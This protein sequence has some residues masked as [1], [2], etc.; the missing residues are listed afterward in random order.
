MTTTK[1]TDVMVDL[2]T[3]STRPNA[4]LLSAGFIAF[5]KNTGECQSVSEGFYCNF[6]DDPQEGRHI[7]I[8]TVTWWMNQNEDARNEVFGKNKGGIAL[9]SSEMFFKYMSTYFAHFAGFNVRVWAKSP[10]FDLIKIQD[11]IG[12]D[13]HCPWKYNDE[14]CVRTELENKD[15]PII[16]GVT[17]HNAI[18][19]AWKQAQE[20]IAVNR[21]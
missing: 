15:V 4:V 10:Q 19:D 3:L 13:K 1:F 18:S 2:E 6:T 9:V 21:R 16:T 17:H 11:Y 8:K 5:N 12:Y 14:R 7:D 20:I